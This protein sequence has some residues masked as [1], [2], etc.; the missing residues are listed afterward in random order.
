MGL[1][2]SSSVSHGGGHDDQV[3]AKLDP[4]DIPDYAKAVPYKPGTASKPMNHDMGGM[5]HSKMDHSK[6]KMDMPDMEG[7]DHSM[8]GGQ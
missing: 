7:M 1:P 6:M 3:V 8:H 5:D 4:S 2:L